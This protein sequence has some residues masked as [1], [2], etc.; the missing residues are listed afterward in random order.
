MLDGVDLRLAEI[1]NA[2]FTGS[3][4]RFARL[5]GADLTDAAVISC[6]LDNSDFR[7]AKLKDAL[8]LD[9]SYQK[10]DLQGADTEGACWTEADMAPRPDH[11][12]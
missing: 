12:L 3:S 2:R 7:R 8:F 11:D 5:S 1:P 6:D 9:S 4:L 10:A